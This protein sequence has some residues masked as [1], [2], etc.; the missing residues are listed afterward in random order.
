MRISELS[1]VDPK[2]SRLH[3]KKGKKR[4]YAATGQTSFRSTPPRDRGLQWLDQE[5][6]KGWLNEG[7]QQCDVGWHTEKRRWIESFAQAGYVPLG[8]GDVHYER[9]IGHRRDG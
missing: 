3:Q 5:G 1:R 8:L 6:R 4:A 9:G 2:S 7:A